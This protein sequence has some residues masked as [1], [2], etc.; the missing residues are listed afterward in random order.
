MGLQ[1]ARWMSFWWKWPANF[2]QFLNDDDLVAPKTFK[3]FFSNYAVTKFAAEQVVKAAHDLNG[4]RTVCVRP[5]NAVYGRRVSSLKP[6]NP[7]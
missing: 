5:S 6:C 2:V 7:C 1:G 4:M 3:D